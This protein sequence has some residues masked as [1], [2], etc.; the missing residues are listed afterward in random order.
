M[1]SLAYEDFL[2]S[3]KIPKDLVEEYAKTTS[4]AFVSWCEAKEKDDFELF[5]PKLEKF[6]KSITTYID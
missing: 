4:E 6:E 3:T 1:I 2:K 5:A